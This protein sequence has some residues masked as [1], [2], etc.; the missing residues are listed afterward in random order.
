MTTAAFT[1]YLA[2]ARHISDYLHDHVD[3]D[4]LF[5][6][7]VSAPRDML[8]DDL[9]RAWQ[10]D[11]MARFD[12]NTSWGHPRIIEAIAAHYGIA[13]PDRLLLTSGASMGF[14]LVARALLQPG[15]HAIVELPHYQPF[16]SVLALMGVRVTLLQRSGPTYRVDPDALAAVI[17]PR[18]R[19]IVLSNPH[20]PTGALTADGDLLALAA[21]ARQHGI[22]IVV[23]EVYRDLVSGPPRPA[24]LLDDTLITISSLSKAYGLGMVRIGWIAAAPDVI[25]QIRPVHTLYEN[26]NSP[27]MQAIASVVF[28]NLAHYQARAQQLVAENRPLVEAFAA[29]L[30]DSGAISGD[31]PPQGCLFFP[32]ITGVRD[33]GRL[34]DTLI[35]RHQVVAVPGEFFGAPG[36][37]RIGFGGPRPM[38]KRGLEKLAAALESISH[39]T[40]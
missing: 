6:S 23:D 21:V 37:L 40:P 7:A 19:L 5:N 31:V 32:H 24:A 8:L 13:G 20:N 11:L 34:V 30:R 33:T 26:T 38:L 14:V 12:E 35:T 36:H 1:D 28:E 16:T 22:R 9:R 27:I 17:T 4:D 2:W 29:L 25:T 15:D 3:T 10:A 39:K 18:T